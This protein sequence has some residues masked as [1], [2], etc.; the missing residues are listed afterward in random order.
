MSVCLPICLR[1]W[2][3]TM[4]HFLL[5][6]CHTS[7][8]WLRVIIDLCHWGDLSLSLWLCNRLRRSLDWQ[9]VLKAILSFSCTS[10]LPPFISVERRGSHTG[11]FLFDRHTLV[12]L[13][14]NR[15]QRQ[16]IRP[17]CCYRPL[18]TDLKQCVWHFITNLM[19]IF[20]GWLQKYCNN[21]RYMTSPR[22]TCKHKYWL[23]NDRFCYNNS[24]RLSDLK[25][26]TNKR[27][28]GQ[29]TLYNKW[30]EWLRHLLWLSKPQ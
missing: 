2:L 24:N 7:P 10:F 3:T 29:A 13:I 6:W 11:H 12:M 9:H 20:S 17:S 8:L 28:I 30:H 26:Q 5:E 19:F 18:T 16:T 4:C 27:P 25:W 15:K 23:Y 14:T 21:L 22:K 1:C